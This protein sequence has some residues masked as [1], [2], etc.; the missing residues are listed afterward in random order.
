MTGPG[1]SRL[2]SWKVQEIFLPGQDVQADR[3]G[4]YPEVVTGRDWMFDLTGRVQAS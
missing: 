1:F 3:Q 4:V 2:L